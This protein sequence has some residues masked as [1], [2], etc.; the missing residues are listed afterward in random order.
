V[1]QVHCDLHLH[2]CTF[3]ETT[4]NLMDCFRDCKANEAIYSV[5]RLEK[6]YNF[7]GTRT[8]LEVSQVLFYFIVQRIFMNIMVAFLDR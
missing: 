7:T 1:K 3:A 4:E 5:F 6:E 2:L 8:I